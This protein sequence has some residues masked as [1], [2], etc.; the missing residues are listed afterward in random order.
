M[1]ENVRCLKQLIEKLLKSSS[2]VF[3][4]GHNEPDFDSIGSAI[5]LQTLCKAL[6][7]EAYIV[8]DE[9]EIDIDPGV[10]KIIDE[11]SSMFNMI[12]VAEC[13]E[14]KD[15]NSLLIMTDVNKRNLIPLKDELPTF[16]DILILDHHEEDHNTINTPHQYI[17]PSIS[18]A[19]EIVSQLL[20]AFRVRY[21][22][23]VAN[24]LLAGIVLDTKRYKKNTTKNTHDE[25]KKLMANGADND[26][27]N[28]LFLEEFDVDRKIND[29]VFNGTFFAHYHNMLL[30][31]HNI[32]FTLNRDAPH[33]IYRKKELAQAAD[34]MLKYRID[35]AFVLG[36]VKEGI[37]N[38]CARGKTHID[39]GSILSKLEGGGSPKSAGARITSDD[40]LEVEELL[41][42]IVE[43]VISPKKEDED[44]KPHQKT[45][46]PN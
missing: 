3:I 4:I 31:D 19:S 11:C 37:V 40:I 39:V 21:S 17:D 20:H 43:D 25:A 7:K 44:Q 38:I 6:G 33:T 13:N 10:K 12:T 5:G 28:D 15:K 42:Q 24:F 34:K 29:L 35:A 30:Q 22:K 18:S 8:L 32:S 36:F 45:K 9:P 26:F 41:M 1:S 23:D 2:K 46:L 14:L 27:V 16:K